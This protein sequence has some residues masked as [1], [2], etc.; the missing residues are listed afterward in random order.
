MNTAIVQGEGSFE[1]PKLEL[2]VI[3]DMETSTDTDCEKDNPNFTFVDNNVQCDLCGHVVRNS[4]E[5]I[6][7][8]QQEMSKK[9]IIKSQENLYSEIMGTIK[10]DMIKTEGSDISESFEG[11]TSKKEVQYNCTHCAYTSSKKKELILHTKEIHQNCKSFTCE[12]CENKCFKDRGKLNAHIKKVHEKKRSFLCD[13]CDKSYLEKAHLEVH[14]AAKHDINATYLNCENC[15]YKTVIRGNLYNHMKY[16]HADLLVNQSDETFFCEYCAFS[17]RYKHTLKAHVD[18]KHFGVKFNCDQ[19]N[20]LFSNKQHRDQHVKKVHLGVSY[21]CNQC[22]YDA[23]KPASLT[24]H[25]KVVHEGKRYKCDSCEY[26][27]TNRGI[28]SAHKKAKHDNIRYNC[29]HCQYSASFITNL[30]KHI[31]TT[32]PNEIQTVSESQFRAKKVI[33]S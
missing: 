5:L 27:T 7:H 30:R 15:D 19:C 23:F 9:K 28:L 26:E 16:K 13:M 22:D 32:H 4:Q 8:W 11:K 29:T 14:M 24:E 31:K 18:G 3:E 6:E 10:E 12:K 1:N 21:K 17:T 25:K 20:S 2:V 33:M